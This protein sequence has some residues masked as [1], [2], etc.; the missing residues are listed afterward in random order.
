MLGD[1]ELGE[2]LAAAAELELFVLLETFDVEDLARLSRLAL[3]SAEAPVIA[4]VNC[5]DL[6]TLTVDFGRFASLA[7]RLPRD[8]PTVAE[9]GIGDEQDIATVA[10]L[11]YR[12]ALVGSALMRTDAAADTVAAFV[13]AGRRA[14]AEATSCS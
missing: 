7:E 4:G 6:K 9:S 11:G 10:R 5:R 12:L 13:A 1:A 2:L 14:A 8:R 3:P